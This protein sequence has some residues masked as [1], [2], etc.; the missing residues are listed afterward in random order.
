[1]LEDVPK[2]G[3]PLKLNGSI[4]LARAESRDDVLKEIE[5]DVYFQNNVWDKSKVSFMCLS[6]RMACS[7]SSF[8]TMSPKL[9]HPIQQ[10]QIFPFASGFRQSLI[11]TPP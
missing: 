10:I 11:F 1:M 7:F 6:K 5:K 9:K 2:E 3:Q 8:G 4:M